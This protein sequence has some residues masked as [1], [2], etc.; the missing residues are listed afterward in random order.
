MSDDKVKEAAD[1]VLQFLDELEASG[2][3]AFGGDTLAHAKAVLHK[4]VDSA[5]AIVAVPAFGRVSIIHEDGRQ[6]T[7]SA[8]DLPFAISQPVNWKKDG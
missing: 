8:S 1:D 5:T 7:I 6:S 4:W 3:A 2:D